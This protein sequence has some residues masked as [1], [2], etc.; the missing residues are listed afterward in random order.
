MTGYITATLLLIYRST[1]S[2]S[3]I[4]VK[5]GQFYQLVKWTRFK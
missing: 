5:I 2:V 3:E 4:N 1:E